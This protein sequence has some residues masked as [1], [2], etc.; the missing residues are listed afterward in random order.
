MKNDKKSLLRALWLMFLDHVYRNARP[1]PKYTIGGF[2]GNN[3]C[4]N[5]RQG[6]AKV[7]KNTLK[8]KLH[9]YDNAELPKI[10]AA[11]LDL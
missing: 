6:E 1:Q 8:N 5:A 2:V 9:N 11:S 7:D 4:D 10:T 3:S